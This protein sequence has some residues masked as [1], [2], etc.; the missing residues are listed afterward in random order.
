[1]SLSLADTDVTFGGAPAT[2]PNRKDGG[3]DWRR[4][5]M[6][7]NVDEDLDLDPVLYAFLF[8]AKSGSLPPPG[9]QDHTSSVAG[10]RDD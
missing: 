8:M 2:P 5:E 9:A 4:S 6:N 3:Q 10:S 1:M 7:N